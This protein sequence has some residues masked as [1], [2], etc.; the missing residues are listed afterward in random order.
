VYDTVEQWQRASAALCK[1]R[2]AAVVSLLFLE[3]FDAR[4]IEHSDYGGQIFSPKVAR[5][6]IFSSGNCE[7]RKI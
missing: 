4:T 7:K 6:E 1:K 5:L 3:F 2:V